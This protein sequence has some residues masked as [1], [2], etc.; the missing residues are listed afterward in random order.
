MNWLI[1]VGKTFTG[2]DYEWADLPLPSSFFP[3]VINGQKKKRERLM[4]TWKWR[5]TKV[6][7]L[8]HRSSWVTRLSV[9]CALN[10]FANISSFV[11]QAKKE[12][13]LS[14]LCTQNDHLVTF[15]CPTLVSWHQ[16]LTKIK[17]GLVKEDSNYLSR[18]LLWNDHKWPA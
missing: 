2:L 11:H 15:S 13:R 1:F 10:F 17:L 9:F 4:S 5:E 7:R 16:V 18:H 6:Q 3:R 12:I 14:H 8:G